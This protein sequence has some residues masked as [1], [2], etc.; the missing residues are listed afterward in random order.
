MKPRQ[1]NLDETAMLVVSQAELHSEHQ[2]ETH[3][4]KRRRNDDEDEFVEVGKKY[5]DELVNLGMAIGWILLVLV[6][7]TIVLSIFYRPFYITQLELEAAEQKQAEDNGGIVTPP[8]NGIPSSLSPENVSAIQFLSYKSENLWTQAPPEE[9]PN[10]SL[11]EKALSAR[12][13]ANEVFVRLKKIDNNPVFD[14]SNPVVT[15]FVRRRIVG[16][17]NPNKSGG[18]KI[19]FSEANE[20]KELKVPQSDE[21]C[22]LTS[23]SAKD[24]ASSTVSASR[25]TRNQVWSEAAGSGKILPSF[26]F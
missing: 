17:V 8:L 3:Q 12:E 1:R 4:Y 20:R 15:P 24:L 6:A 16:L 7:I 19:T 21:N 23:T 10:L 2:S 9:T 14:Y 13:R 5:F 18:I 22:V 25:A 11:Q 26:L